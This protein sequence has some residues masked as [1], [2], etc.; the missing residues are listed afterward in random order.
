M[1]RK[2]PFVSGIFYSRLA[3]N[4]SRVQLFS[5]ASPMAQVPDEVQEKVSTSGL[6][7]LTRWSPQQYVLSHPVSLI[8]QFVRIC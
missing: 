3:T 4:L 7:F 6:G 2:I 1:E 8:L 5:H